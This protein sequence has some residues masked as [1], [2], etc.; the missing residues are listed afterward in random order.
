MIADMIKKVIEEHCGRWLYDFDTK[1][2]N[3]GL[4]G[5]LTLNDLNVKVDELAQYMMPVEI[6]FMH[7]KKLFIDVP[8]TAG[9]LGGKL[10]VQ[11]SG[12][13]LLL[14]NGASVDDGD[15]YVRRVC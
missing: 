9:Q 4:T 13:C 12:V 11:V 6:E 5:T 10:Q 14:K 2:L 8:L 15:R 3:V 1:N 7:V